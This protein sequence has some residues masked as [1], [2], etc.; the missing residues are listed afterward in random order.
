VKR[1]ELLEHVLKEMDALRALE[2][3]EMR[4]PKRAGAE[5]GEKR[6]GKW[7]LF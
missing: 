7:S 2:A 6:G 4:R 5:K 1:K 3:R